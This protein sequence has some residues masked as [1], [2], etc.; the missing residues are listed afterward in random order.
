MIF[1]D[2]IFK[3]KTAFAAALII[4]N[5]LRMRTTVC[6]LLNKVGKYVDCITFVYAFLVFTK[7]GKY[8]K[9]NSCFR[10]VFLLLYPIDLTGRSK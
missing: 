4:N 5:N 3:S 10:F 2:Q 8:L 1:P 6:L 9:I 7:C